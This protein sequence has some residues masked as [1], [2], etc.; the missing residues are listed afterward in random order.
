MRIYRK[1]DAFIT[2]S[3]LADVDLRLPLLDP[4]HCTH[5]LLPRIVGVKGGRVLPTSSLVGPV[6]ERRQRAIPRP[7]P[8]VDFSDQ[9]PV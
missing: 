6:L 5:E 7:D 1:F 2:D 9:Q 3:I 8:K 4:E